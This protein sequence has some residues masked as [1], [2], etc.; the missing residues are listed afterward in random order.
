MVSRQVWFR[1]LLPA[2][3]LAVAVVAAFF[4]A[5]PASAASASKSCVLAGTNTYTCT[6]TITPGIAVGAGS[7]LV[8]M[9]TPSPGTFSGPSVVTSV[10]G[11]A[12]STVTAG[13]TISPQF[14]VADYDVTVGG[15]GCGP[16][17]SVTVTELV[18]VTSSGLLCQRVWITAGAP[19]TSACAN[20]VYTPP[21]PAS[22]PSAT[23]TCT[24]TSTPNV[25]SC[26]FTVVPA[27][28]AAPGDIIHVNEPP[29]PPMTGPGTFTSTP[30][31]VSN[32]GCAQTPAPVVLGSPTSYHATIGSSGCPGVTWSVQF[33]ETIAVTANGQICQSFYMV[34]AVPPTTACANVTYTPPSTTVGGG[35]AVKTCNTTSTPNTYNCTF[36]VTLTGPANAGDPWPVAMSGPGTLSGAPTVASFTGCANAPGVALSAILVNNTTTSTYVA[37]VGAGGCAAG[38]VVVLNE[39]IVVTADGQ[40]CQTVWVNPMIPGLTSC[41]TV[42]FAKS[43]TPPTPPAGGKGTFVAAPNFGA[44]TSA[45]VI[46]NGGT[47]AELEAA[48]L[49]AGGS[50]VWVQ[51]ASGAFQLLIG[52]GPMFLRDAFAAKF[53]GGFTGL[54]SVTVTKR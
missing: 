52:N 8:Q 46:F 36:T 23:K 16:T 49:A 42:A 54:L 35:G 21:P 15:A 32:P 19:S 12:A 11:C 31:V 37:T 22:V 28:P 24:L 5:T 30:T 53:P 44:G 2:V 25:Y 3:V 48:V 47:V 41:A 14:G 7:W 9:I 34:A 38:A 40:I 4:P 1:W 18:T 51:D 29:G 20:V 39:T 6:F 27:F 26:L 45:L 43:L 17:G 13:T 50:G 33:A 10:S